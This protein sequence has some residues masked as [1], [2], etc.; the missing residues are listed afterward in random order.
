MVAQFGYSVTER[1]RGRVALCAVYIVHVETRSISFLVEPQNHSRWFIL[2]TTGMIFSSL[3]SKSVTTVFSGL[4]SKSVV[5]V[6]P[7]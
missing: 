2:K 3:V 4:A 5:K 6:S 1:S 7:V